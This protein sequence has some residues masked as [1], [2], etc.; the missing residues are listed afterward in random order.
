MEYQQNFEKSVSQK[1]VSILEP[2]VGKG[3]VMAKVTASFDFTRSERTEEIYDPDMVAVRSEQKKTEK[4]ISGMP[5]AA[6]IPGVASNLPGGASAS[7]ST[8]QRQ[9]QK[10]D[11]VINYETSKTVQ[12]IVES[13]V[14]LQKMSVA[15][16]IDGI[17]KSQKESIKGSDKYTIRSDEDIR[18]YEDIVKKA[19]GF[20]EDR[21]DEISV[22]V[23]PFAEI[24]K[25]EV[26]E[27]GI[28]DYLP[29]VYSVLKYFIPLTVA[30]IFYLVIL[31]P[32]IKSL[33]RVPARSA[34]AQPSPEEQMQ[35]QPKEIPLEKQVI[36]WASNNPQQAAGLVKGWLEEG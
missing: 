2:V 11:E 5:L 29:I 28:S 19:I 21:G 6:G 33:T 7:V 31:K 3:K 12:R 15:I 34:Q 14:K 13:P 22:K 17:L 1:I 8:T 30:L 9:S 26:P 27:T 16:L 24:D 35:L 4:I 25:G 20:S 18:Y 10:Q 23:M 36:E 32:I